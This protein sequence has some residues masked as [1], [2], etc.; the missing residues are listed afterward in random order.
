MTLNLLSDREL[1]LQRRSETNASELHETKDVIVQ[2][3]YVD[4]TRDGKKSKERTHRATR[5]VSESM[6][7][8]DVSYSRN[9]EVLL[10]NH[11]LK[12]E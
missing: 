10:Q 6:P 9:R 12:W 7:P 5:L 3:A 8:I 2:N 1:L 11:S 4:L